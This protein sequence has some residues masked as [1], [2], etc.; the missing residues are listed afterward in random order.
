MS[1]YWQK[2]FQA[3][4][5]MNNKTAVET[6]QSVTPAFDQAQAHKETNLWN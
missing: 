5:A 4:E 1:N 2:R 3:V 6:V